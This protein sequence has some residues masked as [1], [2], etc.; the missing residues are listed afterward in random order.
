MCIRDRGS[1]AVGASRAC[2]TWYFA[3]G[4]TRPGFDEYICIQ[5]PSEET[6]HVLV[7]YMLENGETP[8]QEVEVA[9]FSRTTVKANDRVGVGHDVSCRITSDVPVIAERPMYSTYYGSNPFWLGA[10]DVLLGYT[11]E[12]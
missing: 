2:L 7:T 1:C 10:A 5:N 12:R 4:C 11:F 3:E 6:A 9:P 8:T